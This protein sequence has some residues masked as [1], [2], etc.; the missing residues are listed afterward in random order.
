MMTVGQKSLILE[1]QREMVKQ[2][3]PVHPL[4][5]ARNSTMSVQGTVY[6]MAPE[7]IKGKGY[8]AKVDI[9]S[10]GCVILEMVTCKHPW[11]NLDEIQ[12]L[13]RLGRFDRP[14][15]PNDISEDC[16]NFLDKTF[17]TTPDDRPS[18]QCLLE[19]PFCIYDVEN[20]DFRAY[21][22]AAIARKKLLDEEDDEDD[23]EEEDDDDDDYDEENEEDE[24][25]E[26]EEDEEMEDEGMEQVVPSNDETPSEVLIEVEEESDCNK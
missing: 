2:F 13:W 19:H 8:S 12:T 17:A 24:E 26:Y 1:F 7:V 14:P 3:N 11:Q 16:R 21:K 23:D 5:Y 15:L 4:A 20:F 6:W 25:I 9:W 18:A 10:L 22:E